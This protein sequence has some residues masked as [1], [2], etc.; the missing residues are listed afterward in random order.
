M[1]ILRITNGF[2]RMSDDYL[3]GRADNIHVSMMGN[4]NFTTPTPTMA[5]LATSIGDFRLAVSKA[6]N[7]SE[8]DVAVKN[9]KRNEL[10]DLLHSLGNY[11]LFT[12]DGDRT[13]AISS[14]FRIAKEPSP[15]PPITKPENLQV[16][17]G[18]NAGELN[19]K[20]K[21]VIGA[22]SYMIQFAEE[23]TSGAPVWQ[24]QTCTTSKFTLKQL[25]SGKKYQV[26]IAVV[27]TNEQLLYSDPVWKIVQ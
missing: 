3:L 17:E 20:F 12:V 4:E 9:D 10:I 27:G 11:V 23:T 21:R 6:E 13:K 8:L 19:I 7:G 15:M 1:T 25:Q 22:R 26:R 2:N 16:A 18:I 24:S 14:G 5:A